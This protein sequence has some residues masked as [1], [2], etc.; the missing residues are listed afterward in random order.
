[1]V[2]KTEHKKK[3]S[4]ETISEL[5]STLKQVQADYENY[6]KRVERDRD[7][8]VKYASESM[9][10][11]FLAILDNLELAL[12]HAVEKNEFQNGIELIYASIIEMLESEGVKPIPAQGLPFDPYRHEALLRKPSDKAENTVL[13]VMQKG[14]TLH[15]RVLR[16]AKVIV[17]AGT[18]ESKQTTNKG[19]TQNE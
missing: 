15:D 16:A 10:K 19:G 8:Y 12:G 6:K 7:E 1:M 18:K 3:N 13:E 11:K 17:S 9:I 4:E 5:T 2:K 14:Y